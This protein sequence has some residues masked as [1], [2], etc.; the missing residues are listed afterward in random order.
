MDWTL[1]LNSY[2][3]YSFGRLLW[4]IV[5]FYNKCVNFNIFKSSILKTRNLMQSLWTMMKKSNI[6]QMAI[7]RITVILTMKQ[8][9]CWHHHLW[10]PDWN[11]KQVHIVFSSWGFNNFKKAEYKH[12]LETPTEFI[13]GRLIWETFMEYC[14]LLQ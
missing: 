3:E 9:K 7:L 10:G 4:N 2:M 1:L 11:Q 13:Y 6:L 14:H 8:I 5:V 12:G